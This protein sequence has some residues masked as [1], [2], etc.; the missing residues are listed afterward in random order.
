[1]IQNEDLAAQ[2]AARSVMV[3]KDPLPTYCNPKSNEKSVF[4]SMVLRL[5][6][7]DDK[8]FGNN[9]YKSLKLVC[10]LFPEVDIKK[11]DRELDKYV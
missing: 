9:Y 2:V 11:L 1:M 5:M 10:D 3:M 6:D 7:L 8:R 4:C